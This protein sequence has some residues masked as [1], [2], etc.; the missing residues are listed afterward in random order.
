LMREIRQET[1]DFGP[2]YDNQGREPVVLP[3]A[4][5]N[6]LVT[7]ARGIA[8]GLATNIPPHNLG[9]VVRSALHLIEN[10]EA[11]TAVLMDKGVKGPDFP[12]G[13]KIIDKPDTLLHM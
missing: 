4:F 3:A 8:V 13:G 2:T 6:M 9:E 7:G 11:S 1:V 5:P 12:R 10:P